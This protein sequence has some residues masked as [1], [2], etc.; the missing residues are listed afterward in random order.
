MNTREFIK[1]AL[2]R[3]CLFFFI[4][5]GVLCLSFCIP[6]EL[7]DDPGE[8]DFLIKGAAGAVIAAC[9]L[10]IIL[11]FVYLDDRK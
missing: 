11:I 6:L 5:A 1:L 2:E 10:T 4:V 3:M 9:V 7:A 8:Y